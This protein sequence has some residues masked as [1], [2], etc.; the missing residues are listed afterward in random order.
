MTRFFAK[1]AFPMIVAI[2]LPIVV[3]ASPLSEVIDDYVTDFD[4]PAIQADDREKILAVHARDDLAHGMKVLLVHDILLK[5]GALE[6]ANMHA[7]EPE[8]FQLSAAD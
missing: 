8:E 5:A 2:T 3:S 6:H 7:A 4:M 1:Y